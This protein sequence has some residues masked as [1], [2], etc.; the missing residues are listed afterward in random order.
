MT[1]FWHHYGVSKTSLRHHYG[2]LFFD[3]IFQETKL[4]LADQNLLRWLMYFPTILLQIIFSWIK[5]FFPCFFPVKKISQNLF[6]LCSLL[7]W[8]VHSGKLEHCT[9]KRFSI[10]D[11]FSK[12]DQIRSIFRIWSHLRKKSLMENFIFC[13]VEFPRQWLKKLKKLR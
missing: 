3:Y 8:S 10:K 2:N 4:K 6:S 5:E 11:F 9:K 1:S 12:Y 7:L 13:A